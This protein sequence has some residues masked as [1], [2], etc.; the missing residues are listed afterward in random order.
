MFSNNILYVFSLLIIYFSFLTGGCG[1]STPVGSSS[2]ENSPIGPYTKIVVDPE[3]STLTD[4]QTLQFTASIMKVSNTEDN[5]LE[6]PLPGAEGTGYT[7]NKLEEFIIWEADEGTVDYN[8]LFKAPD[9]IT[10][11]D[12]VY[13]RAIQWIDKDNRGEAKVLLAPQGVLSLRESLTDPEQIV[14][15]PGGRTALVTEYGSGELSRIDLIT[16]DITTI[17]TGLNAPSGL[18]INSGGTIAWLVERTFPESTIV[19]IN[20]LNP[21]DLIRFPFPLGGATSLAVSSDE[22][23]AMVTTYLTKGVLAKVELNTD[24]PNLTRIAEFYWPTGVVF[25]IGDESVLITDR[26]G[27]LFRINL[28]DCQPDFLNCEKEVITT[29]LG[30]PKSPAIS[31]DG[32]SLYL[33]QCRTIENPELCVENFL[34]KINI[35]DPELQNNSIILTSLGKG[36]NPRWLALEPG[37]NTALI[38]ERRAEPETDVIKRVKLR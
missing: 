31:Q 33:I 28:I 25:E 32:K 37:E 4:G 14:V 11:P 7:G 5:A 16:G 24:N 3:S 12:I 29:A 2:K 26:S 13:V 34:T 30:E 19:R 6:A 36:T 17:L 8:G 38:T 15:E 27:K 35:S 22:R 18:Q 1:A 10:S 20:L 23:V 21:S 9:S